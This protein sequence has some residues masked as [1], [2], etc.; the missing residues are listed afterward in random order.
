VPRVKVRIVIAA[1]AA[2]FLIRFVFAF[3]VG[4]S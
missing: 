3:T 4:S 1:I 2:A